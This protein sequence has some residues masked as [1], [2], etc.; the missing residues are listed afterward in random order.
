MRVVTFKA[1]E[2]LVE[3]L[4][5][6]AA[7]YQLTRSELIRALITAFIENEL[8]KEQSQY[9]IKVEKGPRL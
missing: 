4:D 6:F 9:K 8:K 1:E 7:K 5:R 3:L 2:D